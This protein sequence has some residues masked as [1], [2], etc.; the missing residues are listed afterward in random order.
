M[1][2]QKKMVVGLMFVLLPLAAHAGQNEWTREVEEA[3]AATYYSVSDKNG[4]SLTLA[5]YDE[6]PATAQLWIPS[7]DNP[8]GLRYESP[9]AGWHFPYT[10]DFSIDGQFFSNP[11]ENF[12]R[13][14]EETFTKSFWPALRNAKTLVVATDE[15]T[16]EIQFSVKGLKQ[17]LLSLDDPANPCLTPSRAVAL[18]SRPPIPKPA[19]TPGLPAGFTLRAVIDDPD[20]YTNLRSQKSAK[21]QI[22]ARVMRGEEFFTYHQQGNWWQVRTQNGKVGYM[23]VSRIR[24]LD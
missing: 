7:K 14:C 2:F 16:P 11:F 10:L 22:V 19:T 21:S 12:C 5:C 17:V 9:A 20:G 6:K 23:H 24:L 18:A 15:E 3:S 8:D 13:G 4:N 1:R